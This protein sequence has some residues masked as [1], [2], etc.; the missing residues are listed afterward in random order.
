MG[1]DEGRRDL[2]FHELPLVAFTALATG[3]GGVGT[4]HLLTSLLFGLPWVP[5]RAP[6]GLMAGLTAVGLLVSL[7]HLGRPLRGSRALA[8]L[9]RSPLSN[10]VALVSLLVVTASLAAVLP[11]GGGWR[12]ALALAALLS[13]PLTLLALGLVYRVPGQL[14]WGGPGAVAQPL[15]SGTAFGLLLLMAVPPGV[16]ASGAVALAVCAVIVDGLLF[17]ARGRS[18]PGVA[19]VGEAAH[20][21]IM[22]R[23][24]LLSWLRISAANLVP[25]L[26]AVAGSP[27]AAAVSLGVGLLIDRFLFYGLAVRASTEGEVARVERILYGGPEAMDSPNPAGGPGNLS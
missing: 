27:S 6:L 1:Q 2:G 9:G 12:D 26:A 18:F 24:R 20:P 17:L 19:T 11:R 4:G 23:R 22:A 25:A 3:G 21:R 8:R 10:E 16:V 15:A 7:G 14:T 5:R 13:S